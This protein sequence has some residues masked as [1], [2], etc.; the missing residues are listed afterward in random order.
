MRSCV[1]ARSYCANAPKTLNRNA[2]CG[3]VVSICS[4]RERNATPC[5]CMV[6][7]MW[8]RCDS[9]RP[10]RSSFQTTRQS[11]G[12]T[13][14]APAGV[15]ERSSRAPLAF[16]ANRCRGSTPAAS[17][18][19]RCRSVVC[20]SLSLEPRMYPTSMSE[21][22]PLSRFRLFE[23]SDMCFEHILPGLDG[24]G[25]RVQPGVGNHLLYGQAQSAACV[26][27][28]WVLGPFW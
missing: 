5:A 18:A 12:R 20:R 7:I 16:S 11:P 22:L 27:L 14:Q 1:N 9:E 23:R 17:K 24:G 13:S 8:N 26:I 21:K 19:L 2:P 10:S 28:Q 4:V 15:R 25:K 3:V 6:V